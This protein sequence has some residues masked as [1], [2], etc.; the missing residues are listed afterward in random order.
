MTIVPLTPCQWQRE[1]G[2]GLSESA[3]A[4]DSIQQIVSDPPTGGDLVSVRIVL[5]AGGHSLRLDALDALER[6][7]SLSI[8]SMLDEIEV[9]SIGWLRL[10]QLAERYLTNAQ[11]FDA[12][13]RAALSATPHI[14]R[15]SA[16]SETGPLAPLEAGAGS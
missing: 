13:L 6:A 16:Q 8:G 11:A 10:V 15:Q 9:G 2:S 1:N 12:R 14:A 3:K 4:A 7:C 5:E